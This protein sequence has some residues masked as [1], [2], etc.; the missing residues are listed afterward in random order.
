MR[1]E[2]LDL[3][4]ILKRISGQIEGFCVSDGSPLPA[5]G[6]DGGVAGVSPARRGSEQQRASEGKAF[7]SLI[8]TSKL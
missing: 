6:E 3:N 2:S 5:E 4:D 1:T 8:L 7:P